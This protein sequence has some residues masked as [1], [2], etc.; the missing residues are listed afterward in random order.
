MAT[1]VDLPGAKI[2][3]LFGVT[4]SVIAR[5]RAGEFILI[6]IGVLA[7]LVTCSCPCRLRFLSSHRR[8][9]FF[10]EVAKGAKALPMKVIPGLS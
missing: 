10:V 5:V 8:D 6:E 9:I 3:G 1:S 4:F 7:L 2:R